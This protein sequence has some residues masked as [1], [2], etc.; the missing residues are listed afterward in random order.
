MENYVTKGL[1]LQAEQAV[2]CAHTVSDT[3]KLASHPPRPSALTE[4]WDLGMSTFRRSASLQRSWMDDWADWAGYAQSLPR[5]DTLPKYMAHSGNIFLQ[6][7]AQVVSQLS[8]MSE[9]VDNIAVNYGFW[10]A[11]QIEDA[12]QRARGDT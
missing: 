4:A 7:Q 6:A 1:Q 5:T 2:R 11:Q 3:V 8:E 9:L 10:V 12:E